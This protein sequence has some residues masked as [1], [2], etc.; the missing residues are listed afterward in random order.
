[1]IDTDVLGLQVYSGRAAPLQRL[2][3]RKHGYDE[4]DGLRHSSERMAETLRQQLLDTSRGRIVTLLRAGGRTVEDLAKKLGL[5][6]SAVRIQTAAMERDGVV[7]RAGK[8]PGTTRPSLVYELTPEIEQLLSKAYVPLLMH[9]VD[10]FAQA[11]PAEQVETLLRTTGKG[12]AGEL[13]REKRISEGLE[14]RVAAASALLNEQLGALT[15][16]ES[17][18]SLIIRGDGCPLAAIS[19]KHR[20]VCLAMESLV[21]EIIGVPVRECC[22]RDERPRCCFEVE[23]T[24]PTLQE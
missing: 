17:N 23:R 24:Q 2:T 20:G 3:Q 4:D 11:L 9:L 10:A 1:M 22:D 19:G 8:K 12:L 18:G 21:A 16:V 13:S 14:S 7:K 5:T 15:R 6:S